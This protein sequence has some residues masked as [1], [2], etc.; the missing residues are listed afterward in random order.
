[1]FGKQL[2]FQFEK[3]NGQIFYDEYRQ[4]YVALLF[5]GLYTGY[6]LTEEK[7]KRQAI[8]RYHTEQEL[9]RQYGF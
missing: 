6:G 9:L 3:S 4:C 1:M 5:N 2:E 7:A 8:N